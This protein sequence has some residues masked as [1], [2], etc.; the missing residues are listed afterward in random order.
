MCAGAPTWHAR[1]APILGSCWR[2]LLQA[3]C[4]GVATGCHEHVRNPTAHAQVI[5]LIRELW[6]GR[7]ATEGEAPRFPGGDKGLMRV[8][9]SSIFHMRLPDRGAEWPCGR[10]RLLLKHEELVGRGGQGLLWLLG[11]W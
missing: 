4:A 6:R 3:L 9:P 5:Y 10:R 7:S 11:G 2:S 1:R 8:S